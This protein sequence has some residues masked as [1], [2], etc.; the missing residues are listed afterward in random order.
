MSHSSIT[1][2]GTVSK[3][4]EQ[5]FTSSN[6]SV[7]NLMI[8]TLRYDNRSKEEKAYPIKVNLWGEVFADQLND[9]QVG[10][11]VLVNGRLQL[12]QFTDKNGKLIRL[13]SID[14]S[15]LLRL[16]ELME[17]IPINSLDSS[18]FSESS[19]ELES[20]EIPF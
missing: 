6:K 16:S 3:K 10:D 8:N 19:K 7:I 2:T 11:R 15:R 1:L 13:A 17:S 18:G 4:P 9:F 12:E 5:K 14:A 20:E